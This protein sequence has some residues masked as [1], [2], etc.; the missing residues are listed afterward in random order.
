MKG[1][2]SVTAAVRFILDM[3]RELHKTFIMFAVVICIAQMIHSLLSILV[4]RSID[5]FIKIGTD[6]NLS[7]LK[8]LALV[9]FAA[10][11]GRGVLA[12]TEAYIHIK[13]IV[14]DMDRIFFEKILNTVFELSPG[15]ASQDNTGLRVETVRKGNT[16]GQEIV[17]ILLSNLLSTLLRCS[18]ALGILF[19][20]NWKIGLFTIIA[21]VAFTFISIYI[22]NSFAEEFKK[23]RK[24]DSDVDTQFWEIIKHLKHIIVSAI[25]RTIFVEY[26]K[27]HSVAMD[28]GR[29]TWL[30]YNRKA[31]LLR[32]LFFEH[33]THG[34]LFAYVLYLTTKREIS[35]G[36]VTV[37]IAMLAQIYNALNG[38][39]S[40]QRQLIRHSV[41]V[42]YLKE[43]LETVPL[44]G[45]TEGAVTL[46]EPQGKIAFDNVS[47]AYPG[48]EGAH[49]L[50]N[51][52]FLI[53]PGETVAI[54]GPSGSGKSTAV[55]LLLRAHAP[56][57][58]EILVDDI[59][60]QEVAIRS[61]RKRVGIVHQTTALWDDTLRRNI[62]LGV[63]RDIGESEL[64]RILEQAQVTEF[65]D[66]LGEKWIDTKIGE[67]GIQLS[68][69]QRQRVAIA[70][71]LA[72]NPRVLIFDEATS[73]LDTAT[74]AQ[75]Q[76]AIQNALRGRTGIIIA[77]RLSTVRRADKIIVLD[78][79]QVVGIGN[80][81]G[82]MQT[83]P[84]YQNL[85]AHD[86][87]E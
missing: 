34:L 65:R 25:D 46:E 78:K 80:H 54:V 22:N 43:A 74:E 24:L 3:T 61:W 67:N 8:N 47:F 49:A 52:S 83:C 71:I 82:L 69:G 14:Y 7:E 36:D 53:E 60:L 84:A 5:S 20:I 63:E 70:R 10:S 44:C 75:V 62:T 59:P 86:I 23:L 51:V 9:F 76:Q 35:V 18:L 72:R 55:D 79:G 48:N 4:G 50:R 6:S 40:I 2:I 13:H 64:E 73:A 39:G 77:H 29:K 31:S 81:E 33:V 57:S 38:L 28:A 42:L 37:V 26:Q 58:G 30:S 11:I 41:N 27:R 32:N 17:N 45:D 21:M 85:V 12:V 66:R 19:W 68:G 16:S 15:Q 1:K 56:A 87:R